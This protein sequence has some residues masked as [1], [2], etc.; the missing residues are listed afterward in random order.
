MNKFFKSSILDNIELLES[1][2]SNHSFPTHFH[3]TFCISLI[4]NGVFNENEV[5]ATTGSILISNPNEI[6]C[7]TVQ[8]DNRYS[9]STIY[10]NENIVSY[11]TKNKAVFTSKVITN[12]VIAKQF[13]TVENNFLSKNLEASLSTFLNNLVNKYA[14]TDVLLE[15]EKNKS[16]FEVE[17][18][19]NQNLMN[20]IKL[21]VL[22]K[23]ADLDEFKLIRMFKKNKGLTP[24]EYI[25]IK[26]IEY[27]KKLLLTS[28]SLVHIALDVGF[29]DQSVFSNYFKKYTGLTPAQYKKSCN[30]LQDVK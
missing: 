2:I 16:I 10:V 6:H 13:L 11:L 5:T 17:E 7:N 25:V 14:T 15:P 9:V 30:I 8:T 20:K 19:I 18:Y 23:I 21:S 3:D 1:T 26:R 12:S 29:Y 22:S 24:F 4:K 28:M 27:A